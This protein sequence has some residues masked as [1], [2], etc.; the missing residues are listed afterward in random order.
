MLIAF[1][2]SD[3][4]FIAAK[5]MVSAINLVQMIL[6]SDQC[7]VYVKVVS[8]LPRKVQLFV[9]ETELEVVMDKDKK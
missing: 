9:H 7:I 8:T 5:S 2:N 1:H 6:K 3:I 4:F